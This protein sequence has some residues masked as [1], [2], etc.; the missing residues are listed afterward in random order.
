MS[1]SERAQIVNSFRADPGSPRVLIFSA[2]GTVGLNLAMADTLILLASCSLFDRSCELM[3]FRISRGVLKMN[4]KSLAAPGGN[5]KQ[6]LFTRTLC[7]HW[8]RLTS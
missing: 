2:I 5:L 7:V 4:N 6:K 1:F 8:E 3:L